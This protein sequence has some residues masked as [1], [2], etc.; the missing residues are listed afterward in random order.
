M[1]DDQSPRFIPARQCPVCLGRPVSINLDRLYRCASCGL[2][3]NERTHS[4]QEDEADYRGKVFDTPARVVHQQW[5]WFQTARGE[6]GTG[7]LLDIGCGTGR[8]P[9]QASQYGWEAWGLELSPGGAAQ[10]GE[11]LGSRAVCVSLYDWT[12][13][14]DGFEAITLWDVLDYLGDLRL[15]ATRL[16]AWLRP[17]GTLVVRVRNAAWHVPFIRLYRAAQPVFRLVGLGRSPAVIHR[18][19]FTVPSLVGLLQRA[20]LQDITVQPATVTRGNRSRVWVS[21]LLEGVLTVAARLADRIGDWTGYRWYPTPSIL[22]TAR[23]P[24]V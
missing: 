9:A 12:P 14:V 23:R 8:F 16:T 1:K 10:A 3:L 17:G 4:R 19:G 5:Q 2:I 20:G 7:R 22:V 11:R 24:N 15:A 21:P 13:P 18:H 6:H